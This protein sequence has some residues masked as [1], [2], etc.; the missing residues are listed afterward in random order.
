M[1]FLYSVS[2]SDHI[3]AGISQFPMIWDSKKEVGS[4]FFFFLGCT[5]SSLFLAT[6]FCFSIC[7]TS[8]RN[9]LQ[10]LNYWG[11][12]TCFFIYEFTWLFLSFIL[13]ELREE[14]RWIDIFT[15]S[16]DLCPF[17]G[18]ALKRTQNYYIRIFTVLFKNI[19]TFALERQK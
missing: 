8:S 3:L 16:E 19:M 17:V 5:S 13:M 14:G 6:I 2:Q 11:P 18:E 1:H 7:S 10:V 12:L 15:L 4:F 9:V